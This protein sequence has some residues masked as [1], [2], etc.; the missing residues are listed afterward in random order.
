MGERDPVTGQVTTGHE[1]NGIK[2]L[3]T[4]VP[5]IVFFFLAV[6]I[7]FAV[8][9]WV[10]MPAWPLGRTYTKGLLGVDQKTSVD[11]LVKDATLERSA[12]TQKIDQ[13][14]FAAIQADPEMMK[15]VGETG[16]TLF[17]DNCAA[18]HGTKAT[19]GPGF[20]NLTAGVWLWGGAPETIFE[21]LRIGI[22]S[23]HPETRTSQMLAFGR[24]GVLDSN[25]LADVVTYVRSLG[26]TTDGR[27]ADP[28]SIAAGQEVFKQN[29]VACHGDDAKG[30]LDLGTPDLTD[31]NWIYG[32][33]L[34]SVTTTVFDG[35]QGI[36]PTWEQRLTATQRKILALYVLSLREEGQ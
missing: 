18:C 33:D 23:T 20:P 16:H 30:K 26:G 34:Q 10:L 1:W 12:W 8:C 19:G 28:Q 13:M 21:T 25:Q 29:C 6:T 32:G 17:G 31:S 7:L 22:N 24:E 4:P 2:E 36:M 27:G 35:R 15:I 5:R 14:D 11:R 9:Y 3:Y